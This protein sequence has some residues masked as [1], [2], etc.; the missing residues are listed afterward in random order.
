MRMSLVASGL[1]CAVSAWISMAPTTAHA[2]STTQHGASCVAMP[3]ITMRRDGVVAQ[4]YAYGYGLVNNDS[5]TQTVQCPVT[6]VG[7]VE[8]NGRFTVWIDGWSPNE[9][10]KCTLKSFDYVGKQLAYT[11]AIADTGGFS[12]MLYL[13]KAMVPNYSTQFV[14][15]ELPP[16]GVIVGLETL[17]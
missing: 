9:R 16:S 3:T 1:A 11:E 15:C 8:P 17:L 2:T 14:E 4:V 13:P 10:T 12:L 7:D 5:E 6:R